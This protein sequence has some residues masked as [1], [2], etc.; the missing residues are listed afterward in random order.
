MCVHQM[1]YKNI[2]ILEEIPVVEES[3][4]P[5]EAKGKKGAKQPKP[6]KKTEEEIQKEQEEAERKAEEEKKRAEKLA[7]WIPYLKDL[8]DK[9]GDL[10]IDAVKV[11][12]LG[13]LNEM[14]DNASSPLMELLME[15]HEPNIAFIPSI[16]MEE[17][18]NFV[19]FMEG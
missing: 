1:I 6:K 5:K 10:M 12:Q 11:N 8:D 14:S 15:L 9:I 19:T 13:F 7:M 17:P 16:I 3:P 2:F 4:P 18:H